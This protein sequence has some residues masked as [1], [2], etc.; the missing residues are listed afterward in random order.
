MKNIYKNFIKSFVTTF[1][2]ALLMPITVFAV[3]YEIGDTVTFGKYEQDNDTTNG[4]EDIEWKVIDKNGDYHLLLSTK[5][6]DCMKFNSS[7]GHITYASCSLRRFLNGSFYNNSFTA[8]EKSK[9][10][11]I[12]N[13]NDANVKFNID[14]GADTDDY[15]FILS[16]EEYKRYF[17]DMD[18][19]YENK[20]A[21]AVGTLY[22][23][24]KGLDINPHEE[25]WCAGHS[26]Y[27]LRTPGSYRTAAI[28]VSSNGG[29]VL[30]GDLVEYSYGVRPAVWVQLK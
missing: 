18:E 1:V 30:W 6:L 16:L 9:I 11:K 26:P 3:S 25:M 10:F 23:F 12:K 7:A 4:K 28:Y 8:D 2:I 20:D 29:Y 17:G 27:W 13:K 24:S 21:V 22:A 14:A 5:I 19:L 15:A